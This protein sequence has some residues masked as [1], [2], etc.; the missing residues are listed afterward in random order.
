M[1]ENL[2]R[3]E[4]ITVKGKEYTLSFDMNAM[5]QLEEEFNMNP[6]DNEFY[7]Y[8]FGKSDESKGQEAGDRILRPSEVIKLFYSFVVSYHNDIKKTDVGRIIDMH[9]FRDVFEQMISA[10]ERS[11][12][13]PED[14]ED[15]EEAENSQTAEHT[16]QKKT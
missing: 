16:G 13:Q 4:K 7:E 8:L 12:P 11:M 5:A 2:N 10:F 3:T 15:S 1:S 9:N 6:F 14:K